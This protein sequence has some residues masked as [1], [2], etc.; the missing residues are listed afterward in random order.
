[1]IYLITFMLIAGLL[2]A[3]SVKWELDRRISFTWAVAM[4]LFGGL[5]VNLLGAARTSFSPLLRV[6][7]A[8]ASAG[9]LTVA[10]ILIL[11]FRNPRR[12]PPDETGIIVAPADGVIKYVKEIHGGELPF[13]L[14][15]DQRIPLTEFIGAGVLPGDCLQ[16]GIGMS[17]LDVHINRSPISGKLRLLKRIP[18]RFQSLKRPESLALNE[19][20]VGVVEGPALR[21]GLVLIASRLVRR[22]CTNVREGQELEIG[23]RIGMIRFG[24]Q[25]DLLIPKSTSV[26]IR[27]RPGDKVKAGISVIATVKE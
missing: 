17:L 22:I 9:I 24:S 12:T 1:M 14:K 10:A 13:A 8:G 7:T 21:I 27:A 26:I 5:I 2:A 25:T 23:Q 20:V 6:S 19:R 16:I 18:G 15:K 11:F 3:V 4:G